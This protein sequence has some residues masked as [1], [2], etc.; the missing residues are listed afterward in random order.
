[1]ITGIINNLLTL[2]NNLFTRH[3]IHKWIE[4]EILMRYE[5]NE[6]KKKF[7]S[8]SVFFLSILGFRCILWGFLMLIIMVIFIASRKYF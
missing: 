1:M 4:I 2:L 8:V 7:L 6:K 5:V 3:L